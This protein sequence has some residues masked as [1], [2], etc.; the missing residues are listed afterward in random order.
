LPAQIT[1]FGNSYI[2]F[3]ENKAEIQ[4]TKIAEAGE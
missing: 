3:E 1:K 4:F 2:V